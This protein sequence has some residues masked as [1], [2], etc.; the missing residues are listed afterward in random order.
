MGFKKIKIQNSN[1]C[2][3][4]TR[5]IAFMTLSSEAPGND[6]SSTESAWNKQLKYIPQHRPM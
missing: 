4:S 3:L 2:E 5:A 1:K 6:S